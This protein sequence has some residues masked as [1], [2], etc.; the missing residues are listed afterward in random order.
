MTLPFKHIPSNVRLPLFWAE[1]DNSKANT[2]TVNQR[3]LIIGQMTGSGTAA[4]NVPVICSG[5]S[6]AKSL[7]GSGS[8]LA[9]MV[10]AYR[11]ND[12]FGELWILPV[13]DNDSAIAASGTVTIGGAPTAAGTIYLYIA[14]T[15]IVQAVTSVMTTDQIAAALAETVSS[16]A[17]L[18]VTATASGSVVTL[19]ALNAGPGGNEID[20]RLN[21]QGRASGEVLPDGV[22]A[23]ISAMASGAT[24]PDLTVALAS[25]GD[26]L[27]DFI[28]C[29]Y[30]DATSL[31]AI[32]TMLDDSTGRWSWSRKIYGHAFAAYRGTLSAATTFG[33]TRNDPHVSV[34]GFNDSP[35]PAWLW[36]SAL[37]AQA[38][39]SV[40]ADPAQPIR[41]VPLVGVLAPPV[42]SR[43]AN[44]DRNTLLFDGISTFKVGDDGTVYIEKLITTY[45]K[46]TFGQADN[47]F[48]DAETLFNLAYCLRRL[49]SVVT[50]KYGRV[51]L[52]SD[53]TRFAPGSNI[54]TPKTIK[55]DLIAEYRSMEYDGYVQNGDAFKAGLIVQQN[56]SN[57]NRVDVLWP[58]ILIDRLDVFALLAQFRLS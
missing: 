27:F 58:G 33:T 34:I 17:D 41:E 9:L 30:A 1:I 44:T 53:N 16:T 32:K 19:T 12:S 18:P 42:A 6:D 54:V 43:F 39:V 52:A 28:V 3:S 40:R 4:A 46:N 10:D 22:T 20:L 29:P 14:G 48:L 35:T 50:S 5:T 13:N 11:D 7:A 24:A 23:S 31:N 55:A 36:A 2:A 25:L 47:S 21:Y 26:Q 37:S 51:K 8:M 38:A 49:E 45:Q 56:T 15:R 57:P